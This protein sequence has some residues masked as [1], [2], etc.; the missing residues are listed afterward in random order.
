MAN[1]LVKKEESKLGFGAF[2]AS[3]NIKNKISNA[4]GKANVERFTA[5]IVSAVSTNPDLAKCDFG[6][7]VSCALIG[8]SLKLAPSPSLGQM[9]IVPFYNSKE[10]TFKAQFQLSYKSYIQLAIR[11]GHYKKIGAIEIKEGELKKCDKIKEIYEFETIENE[12]IRNNTPTIG[13]Y[14]YFEMTN[15]FKKELYWD[16]KKTLEHAKLYS[17]GYASD[18]KNG[19]QYTLWSKNTDMMGTKTVLR[20]LLSKYGEMSTEM[21]TAYQ[22]DMAS[23]DLDGNVDYVDN[24]KDD[25]FN[26]PTI[27]TGNP[28]VI[29]VPFSDINDEDYVPFPSDAP[30]IKDLEEV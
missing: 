17:T 20:Q 22:N 2:M 6:S 21:Q 1:S 12:E 16:K 29:D 23:V 15:G 26:T 5:S 25:K 13:Y 3:E 7:I 28:S 11:T 14:A 27:S 8:E 9:Y 4:I 19:T 24:H 18:I 10:K 30:A